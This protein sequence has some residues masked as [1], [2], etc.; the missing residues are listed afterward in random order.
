M[1]LLEEKCPDQDGLFD[2]P[3]YIVDALKKLTGEKT[4]IIIK[5]ASSSIPDMESAR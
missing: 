4:Q 5:Q 1:K 2:V 3:Y